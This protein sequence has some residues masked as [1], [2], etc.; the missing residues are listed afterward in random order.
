MNALD[1]IMP[2]AKPASRCT[3]DEVCKW[4]K[5]LAEIGQ[6]ADN[7]GAKSWGEL[8][9]GTLSAD[10]LTLIRS[11]FE[12]GCRRRRSLTALVEPTTLSSSI[13]KTTKLSKSCIPCLGDEVRRF[14][15]N[16]PGRRRGGEATI[17]N[18]N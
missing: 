3:F 4:G 17:R 16:Q 15:P 18:A 12:L 11:S 7:F 1:P 13:P 5:R 10:D 9:A 14:R 8:P 2:N 6:I